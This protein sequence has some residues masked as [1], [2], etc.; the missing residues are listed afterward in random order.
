MKMNL[1]K[2]AV[3]VIGFFPACCFADMISTRIIDF[4]DDAEEEITGPNAGNVFRSSSDLEIGNQNGVEQWVGL[5]YQN[6]AI[7]NGSTIN[8]V[9]V[10]FTSTALDVGS[11]V[12]PIVGQLSPDTVSF[13]D[14]DKLTTRP[15][16]A[17][18]I[19]WTIPVWAPGDSGANTTTPDLAGIVQEIVNQ[20]GWSSGNSMVFLFKN[21]PLET[22][23]RSAASFDRNP[24]LSALLT[25]D[26]SPV[27]I[28]EPTGV[29]VILSVCW[30]GLIHRQFP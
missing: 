2:V 9:S 1:L 25:V 28:P 26:F 21:Q 11:L 3:V 23:E 4:R 24:A 16:T 10:Q 14:I 20:G 22:S 13:S 27:N 6:I 17:A 12:I 30:F 29:A 15:L 18:Q 5:R 8:S 19:L 7:P